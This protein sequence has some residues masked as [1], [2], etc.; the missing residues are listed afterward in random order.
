MSAAS[1]NGGEN[2]SAS[3]FD[4]AIEEYRRALGE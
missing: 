3:G 1:T 2:G 4:A